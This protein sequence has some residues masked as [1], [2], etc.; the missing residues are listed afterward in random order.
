MVRPSTRMAGAVEVRKAS[1]LG[2]SRLPSV[3]LEIE[4]RLVADARASGEAQKSG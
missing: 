3:T 2:H 4:A 1:V